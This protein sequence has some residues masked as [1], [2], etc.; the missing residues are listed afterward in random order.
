MSG[1]L[2]AL[3]SEHINNLII[4]T[5]MGRPTHTV[6]KLTGFNAGLF[7][8]YNGT[9]QRLVRLQERN[10]KSNCARKGLKQ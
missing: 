3:T 4:P 1:I 9:P 5:P 8:N 6:P 2:T 7:F 10:L